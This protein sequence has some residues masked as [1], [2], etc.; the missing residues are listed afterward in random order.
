MGL[1]DNIKKAVRE[2]LPE[3]AI[4]AI[5]SK[6]GIDIDGVDNNKTTTTK[7]NTVSTPVSTETINFRPVSYEESY[8]A[9]NTIYDCE[10]DGTDY[11]VTQSFKMLNDFVEFDSGAGEIDCSFVFSP[12]GNGEYSSDKPVIAIGFSQRDYEMIMGYKNSGKIPNGATITK[13]ENCVAEYKTEYVK[14]ERYIVAYH[15]FKAGFSSI[16]SQMY[17]EMPVYLKKS[18][19]SSIALKALEQMVSTYK[20]EKK[21]DN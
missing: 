6:I 2:N 16:Y 11:E 5:E 1:F 7:T 17:V 8:D 18:M 14:N 13:L 12:S 19:Q 4:N 3:D 10:E 15:F 21:L 20:E 9:T